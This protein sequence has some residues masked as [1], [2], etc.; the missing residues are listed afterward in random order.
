MLL[1]NLVPLHRKVAV[2]GELKSACYRGT[3][4]C[5][6]VMD[7]CESAYC[8]VK[9]VHGGCIYRAL[10]VYMCKCMHARLNVCVW[11]GGDKIP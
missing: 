8:V 5:F 2:A 11:G 6:A 9:W 3:S 7:V 4:V 1:A 10:H